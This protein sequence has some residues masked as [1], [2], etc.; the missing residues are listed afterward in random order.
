MYNSSKWSFQ[1]KM[2]LSYWS[3]TL[4][5]IKKSRW[6]RQKHG[7]I[8]IFLKISTFEQKNFG[9]K[10]LT[11][12]K[13]CSTSTQT[14]PR[15]LI[16]AANW[17]QYVL[18]TVCGVDLTYFVTYSRWTAQNW[19]F[20][21]KKNENKKTLKSKKILQDSKYTLRNGPTLQFWQQLND[22]FLGPGPL[23]LSYHS[24][25]NIVENHDSPITRAY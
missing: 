15:M 18:K 2:L 25:T 17:L 5:R 20:S 1:K 3:E 23:I 11:F 12:F 16:N 8:M 21:A 22:F 24:T 4:L 10:S 14:C 9:E 6:S 19:H 13:I 7:K